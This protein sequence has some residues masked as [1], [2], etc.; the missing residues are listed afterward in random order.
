MF[1]GVYFIEHIHAIAKQA[2]SV[3]NHKAVVFNSPIGHNRVF[4]EVCFFPNM[5][6]VISLT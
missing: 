4:N 6:P 3:F 2:L 1:H 5:S